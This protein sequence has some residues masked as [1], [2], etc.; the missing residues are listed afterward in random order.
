M[1]RW[2]AI[3]IAKKIWVILFLHFVFW[4]DCV[5]VSF[6]FLVKNEIRPMGPPPL[7]CGWCLLVTHTKNLVRCRPWV[8]SSSI[9]VQ[10]IYLFHLYREKRVLSILWSNEHKYPI[11]VWGTLRSQ[12][13]HFLGCFPLMK[14]SLLWS[15]P[16]SFTSVTTNLEANRAT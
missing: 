12:L 9:F 14:K 2:Y 10:I 3:K 11:I 16:L 13:T 7:H 8:V 1:Q 5:F 6:S 15:Q 4:C